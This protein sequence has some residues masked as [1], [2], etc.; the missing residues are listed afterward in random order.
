[1]VRS[2]STDQK[3]YSKNVGKYAGEV[4]QTPAKS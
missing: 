2:A 3:D 1:M 4:L